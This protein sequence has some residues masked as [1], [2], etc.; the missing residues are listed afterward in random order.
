MS[1]SVVYI[2]NQTL[3]LALVVWVLVVDFGMTNGLP[4]PVILISN[5][6][7]NLFHRA[8]ILTQA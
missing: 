7:Y 2:Y 1:A 6:P 8:C 5:L 3:Y 4:L